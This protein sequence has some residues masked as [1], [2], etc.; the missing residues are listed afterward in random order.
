M[1]GDE[2][3]LLSLENDAVELG[4]IRLNQVITYIPGKR[5]IH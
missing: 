5:D 3:R 4:Q 1:Y 2:R